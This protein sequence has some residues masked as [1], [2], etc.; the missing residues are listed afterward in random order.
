MAYFIIQLAERLSLYILGRKQARQDS[1]LSESDDNH[2][3][4]RIVARSISKFGGLWHGA[5][6]SFI[7]WG[8][9]HGVSLAIHKAVMSVFPSFKKTGEEMKPWRRV[10]G[11]L[12]TFHL[13]AFG[14][15]FFRANNIQTV[16]D[17]LM[18]ICTNFHPEIFL[19]FVSGYKGVCA[20]MIIG[21][22]F[23]FVPKRYEFRIRQY[24]TDA[25]FALQALLLIVLIFI[26][27]QFKSAGVQPFIYFQ[28]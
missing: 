4:R 11:V 8:G 24:V 18:Q 9:L 6:V 28:F 17:M 15:I 25:S 14:W 23:H 26:V 20:L 7:I 27:V 21:Y 2:A 19:Q 3:P 13:V 10:V 22:I 12:F 1:N 16:K 5:S